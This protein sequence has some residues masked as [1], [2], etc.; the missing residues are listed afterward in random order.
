MSLNGQLI[1]NPVDRTMFDASKATWKKARGSSVMR[2]EDKNGKSIDV[3]KVFDF[4]HH[5]MT[6]SVIAKKRE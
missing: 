3:L 2:V 4:D 5:R 6:Q 1:G